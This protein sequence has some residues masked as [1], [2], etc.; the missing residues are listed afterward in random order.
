MLAAGIYLILQ[1]NYRTVGF[2]LIREDFSIPWLSLHLYLLVRALRVRTRLSVF[3]AALFFVLAA[4]TW[5]AMGFML[6][7]EAAVILFWF[8]RSGQNP[9]AHENAWVFPIT[10]VLGSLLVPVLL[11][12]GFLFSLPVLFVLALWSAAQMEKREGTSTRWVRLSAP[13]TLIALVAASFG[14]SW[15]TGGGRADYSH[16]FELMSSKLAHLGQLPQD[17]T[18]LSFDTRLLCRAPSPRRTGPTSMGPLEHPSWYSWCASSGVRA[19]GSGEPEIRGSCAWW[20]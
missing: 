20:L 4:A 10:I 6:T 1:G 11:A 5:H 13:I 19:G 7:I 9:L 3:W 18:N 8:L 17:P 2:V 12:K 15:L 14:L 16:V